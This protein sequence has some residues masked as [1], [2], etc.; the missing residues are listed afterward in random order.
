MKNKYSLLAAMLGVLLTACAADSQMQSELLPPTNDLVCC[1][2]FSLF[3]FIQL[4]DN[5]NIKFDIDLTSSVATFRQGNSY[6]SAFRF[7][8][9]SEDVQVMVSSLMINDSVFAPEILL[10]DEH[11]KPSQVIN[12]SDFQTRPSNA[13]TRTR[14]VKTLPINAQQTPYLVI[15][16]P[17]E[18]LGKKIKVDHPAKVRAKELGEVMPMV[19]DPVYTHRLGG[20][21]ELEVKT[22][23]RRVLPT[24]ESVQRFDYPATQPKT[25]LR[26]QPESQQFYLSAITQALAAGEIAKALSLLDEAKALNIPG[27]QEAFVRA[28]NQKH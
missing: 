6:F 11:F 14:Y 25:S 9:R 26:V 5:D 22:L 1:S 10:L 23:K 13:F 8:D 17:A 21:I 20:S 4:N 18:Q 28:V 27:A 16:T 2:D 24:N 3:P 19:T 15:Y 12:F 7:S